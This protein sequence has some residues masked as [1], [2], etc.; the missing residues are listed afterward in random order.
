MLQIAAV[1]ERADAFVAIEFLNKRGGNVK[2]GP[3]AEPPSEDKW[4]TKGAQNAN[5]VLQPK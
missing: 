2:F 5:L 1:A 3:T 4:H